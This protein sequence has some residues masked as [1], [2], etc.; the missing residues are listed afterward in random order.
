MK[1]Q[2]TMLVSNVPTSSIVAWMEGQDVKIV[3]KIPIQIESP[4]SEEEKIKEL[5]KK[6]GK[7]TPDGIH[8]FVGYEDLVKVL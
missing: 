7:K 8:E 1:Y 4:L 6:I 2:Y 3:M 5:E